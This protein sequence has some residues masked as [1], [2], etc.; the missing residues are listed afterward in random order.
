MGIETFSNTT[1]FANL[2]LAVNYES[3]GFLLSGLMFVFFAIIMITMLKTP[4]QSLW[5]TGAVSGFGAFIPSLLTSTLY[6]NSTQAIPFWI[7]LL[8]GLIMVIGMGG[9]YFTTSKN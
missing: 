3:S 2:V 4:D 1:G 7:P 9:M 5:E 6:F 8:F